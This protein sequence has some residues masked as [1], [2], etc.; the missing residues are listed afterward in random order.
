MINSRFIFGFYQD[1][2]NCSQGDPKVKQ[3]GMSSFEINLQPDGFP[4]YH[5][6]YRYQPGIQGE[7]VRVNV[8]L[9]PSD[10]ESAQC[11]CHPPHIPRS[12]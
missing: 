1:P 11:S 9:Q 12:P 8:S 6:K 4:V 7:I 5:G 10:P 2:Q 3:Q